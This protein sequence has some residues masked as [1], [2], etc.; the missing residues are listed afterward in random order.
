MSNKAIKSWISEVSNG[1]S[2]FVASRLKK[3]HPLNDRIVRKLVCIDKIEYIWVGHDRIRVSN[4]VR[5]EGTRKIPITKPEH[6]TAIGCDLLVDIPYKN[7]QFYE[8]ASAE[9][10]YGETMLKAVLEAIDSDWE[11]VIVMDF[12]MGFWDVMAERY[13]QV[14]VM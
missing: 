3:I 12:S 4:E 8:I 5:V 6:P 1:K 7:V 11:V 14:V 2:V 9:K 13:E 10:G